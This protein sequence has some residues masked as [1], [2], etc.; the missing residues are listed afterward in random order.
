MKI[1]RIASILL[2]FA[3]CL[4]LYAPAQAAEISVKSAEEL[5]EALTK[6]GD[7]ILGADIGIKS[8]L[9]VSSSSNLDLNG[10]KLSVIPS[11]YS[12]S[13]IVIDLGQTLTISD[14]KYSSTDVNS[15]KLYVNAYRAGIQTSGAS[16]VINSGVVEVTGQTASGIG[17]IDKAGY[18][19]GGTV[20]I[21]GG[22]VTATGGTTGGSG[23]AGIG[24][25]SPVV[26]RGGNGGTVIINGGTVT[27]IGGN[28]GAGIGGGGTAGTASWVDPGGA[29]GDV[30]INGGYVQAR[31]SKN[32]AADIGGGGHSVDGG[33]LKVFGGTLELLETGTNASSHLFKN[34][35][36]TGAGAGIYLGCYDG[37]GKLILIEGTSMWATVDVS[38][39]VANGLVPDMM[40]SNYT[41]ATTRAEFCALAVALY[42]TIMGTEIKERENFADTN[43]VNIE[44]MGALGVVTG[45]GN[46]QFNPSGTLTREQAAT[47]LARLAEAIGKPLPK[48]GTAFSDTAN[49]SSWAVESVGQ[50]QAVGIMS[51][52][53]N[54]LFD[55]SGKYTREQSIITMLR[56]FNVVR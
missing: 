8:E 54:N 52:V 51:G 1:K 4:S 46:N 2:T 17:G 43:D 45:V 11:G 15:G 38:L 34:C 10:Y 24:G 22:I 42:E 9:T 41:Q 31:G 44:K 47:M 19:D 40:M 20:T 21:N 25:M 50:V 7:I 33:T 3:L 5:Q 39:A 36:V 23:G 14:Q 12:K 29:G 49:I 30:T 6:G 32:G 28:Y 37:D 13:G 18:Y 48:Q 35:V 55:P 27:A 26:G 56:L 16:L 53:G